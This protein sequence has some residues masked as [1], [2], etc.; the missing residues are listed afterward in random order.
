MPRVLLT[1]VQSLRS[2]VDELSI[3]VSIHKVD[4]ICITETWLSNEIET[5]LVD[6]P[7]Y[8]MVRN[9]RLAR[10]GGGTA[11]YIKDGLLFKGVNVNDHLNVETEGTFVDFPSLNLC[12]F[13]LYI[14]PQLRTETQKLT[15]ANIDE[16]VDNFM[17]GHPKR[18]VII[19][20]DFND[21]DVG[22]VCKDLY[23]ADIV[24]EPTRGQS[25]LDHIM[26]SEGLKP[27]YDFSHVSY[28]API[29]KSDHLT[30]VLS[31]NNLQRNFNYVRKVTVFDFRHSHLQALMRNAQFVDWQL[32]SNTGE[33]IDQQWT[34]LYTCIKT[35]VD[36][37]IPQ[38]TVL[39][40]S[41][42]KPWMTPVTKKLI[43]DKWA[44][45]RSNDWDRFHYLKAKISNEIKKAK[46][47]WAQK[48]KQ[49]PTSLWTAVKQLSGKEF[50]DQLHNLITEFRTP[51]SLAEAIAATMTESGESITYTADFAEFEDDS[52]SVKL[53]EFEVW[54][55]LR[56]L[57]PKKSAGE[58]G[59]P[60]K[61][62]SILADYIA[63]PLKAIFDR[64]ISLRKFPDAWKRGIVVPIPKTNPP[65][66]HNMRTITLLPVP[67]KIL[68]K[69]VLKS[70][71][72]EIEPLLGRSQ[73]A[74]RKGLST[75]TALL[76][77]YDT[78]T[79]IYDDSQNA[80]LAILSLDF[81]KAFDKVDHPI[82]L[83]KIFD[84]FHSGFGWWLMNYLQNRC[85]QVKIQGE[86]S[87]EYKTH[88]GVPQGSVL[89]PMLFLILVADLPP[90]NTENTF[91]QYA[92]DVN[93][94]IQLKTSDPREMKQKVSDQLR[95]VTDWCT[96]NK[97]MLNAGKTK[98]L[99][100]MRRRNA[101]A[102]Y[103]PV[104]KERTLKILGVVM[105]DNLSWEDHIST[106]AKRAA[107]RLYILRSI[108][109]FINKN[110]LH[111]VYTALIRSICDYCCPVFVNLPQKLV[112]SLQRIEK[113]AHKIIYGDSRRCS[114]GLDGFVTRR[115]ALS[116]EVFLKI[117]KD[118][119]H[120]LQDRMP[121]M[122][123][124]NNRF[125]NFICRTDK[126]QNSF[127]PSMTLYMNKQ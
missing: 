109:P 63:S 110:E 118:K 113:R 102:D 68:E 5:S 3:V 96:L 21:F 62:Y 115:E 112:K 108:K 38:R 4:I 40:T 2:K 114:C 85:F 6:I 39:L 90:Q 46:T 44:A 43:N 22:Q 79:R 26:I 52:W 37:S 32:V 116:K 47:L 49:S 74:Y 111:Q 64:S 104:V 117:L 93:V 82:L 78:A 119:Q 14:P 98:L 106:V 123:P 86:L 48:L 30:L 101:D 73:H 17:N 12:M 126:R 84:N 89:G 81:T 91:V 15:L 65:Q 76:Q 60:N 7:G 87:E 66:L 59:I 35:L 99:T 120:P 23:L 11:M 103:G 34:A 18:E 100:C 70:L 10:R 55:H 29:G 121:K 20:G 122:L 105:N 71:Q 54:N 8:S 127:F 94:I 97:Q 124:N 75:T 88:T 41:R 42:D 83:Q 31:P 19:L 58:D 53:S 51:R 50:K 9:D 1:N 16:I 56:R 77:I 80:G 24:R 25:I 36:L 92:D 33:D 61:I 107:R 67:S 57:S 13:C 28:E 45:F 27:I 125:S 72:K 95:E 69:V